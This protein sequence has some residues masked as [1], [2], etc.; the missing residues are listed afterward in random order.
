MCSSCFLVSCA[1]LLLFLLDQLPAGVHSSGKLQKRMAAAQR[2]GFGWQ[3]K[4]GADKAK[5][6]KKWKSVTSATDRRQFTR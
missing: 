6:F 5:K 1:L 4:K 2:S 3:T